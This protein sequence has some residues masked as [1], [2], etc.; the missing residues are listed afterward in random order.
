MS[1]GKFQIMASCIQN[2]SKCENF[3]AINFIQTVYN[4]KII[5]DQKF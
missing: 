2:R 4:L 1:T 5:Y 3:V